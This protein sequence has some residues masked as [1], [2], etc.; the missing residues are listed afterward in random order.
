MQK[1]Q[2]L[3]AEYQQQQAYAFEKAMQDAQMA[4]QQQQFDATMAYNQGES[5]YQRQVYAAEMMAQAGDFSGFKALGFTD[6]QI[7]G[8][9]DWYQMQN[10]PKYSTQYTPK[11]STQY[12]PKQNTTSNQNRDTYTGMIDSAFVQMADEGNLA[13][14]IELMINRGN[15]DESIIAYLNQLYRLGALNETLYYKYLGIMSQ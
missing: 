9:Q 3:Y 13:Q 7:A 2:A 15:S 6:E 4:Q 14:T 10:T 8:L 5:D 12:T 11:Y 1:A